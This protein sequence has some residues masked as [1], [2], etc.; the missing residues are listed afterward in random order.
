MSVP[1]AYL[2][3]V[4]TWSTT[5]L[6]IQWSADGSSFA[7]AVLSRMVISVV[8]AAAI[9]TLWRLPLPLNAVALYT[10][11]VPI[12]QTLT[13]KWQVDIT[14]ELLAFNAAV[15][16]SLRI[17]GCT[18]QYAPGFT[19]NLV[20]ALHDM[21]DDFDD[22]ALIDPQLPYHL[23]DAQKIVVSQICSPGKFTILAK[24]GT[25]PSTA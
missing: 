1:A 19:S 21:S 14:P 17:A 8:L 18:P 23:F 10:L 16:D 12:L 6:A 11:A 15:E 20:T 9:M 22:S 25:C 7:F 4:L 5:P 24:I 2:C 3:I 13:L